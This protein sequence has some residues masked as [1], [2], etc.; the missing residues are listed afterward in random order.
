MPR[1]V[2]TT[3]LFTKAAPS[4]PALA[5]THAGES[6]GLSHLLLLFFQALGHIVR[7]V[8]ARSLQLRLKL[9]SVNSDKV[10]RPAQA[11][12]ITLQTVRAPYCSNSHRSTLSAPLRRSGSSSQSCR[13]PCPAQAACWGL[14]AQGR[15]K[16]AQRQ[17]LITARCN[18]RQLRAGVN[19]GAPGSAELSSTCEARLCGSLCYLPQDLATNQRSPNMTTTT[20][21]MTASSGKPRPNKPHVVTCCAIHSLS[22]PGPTQ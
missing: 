7:S 2:C 10:E 8:V 17:L 4:P 20:P 6:A 22:Q 3:T 1:S 14:Q 18:A 13:A 16:L 15:R 12:H 9:L 19:N 5:G 11:L 21:A